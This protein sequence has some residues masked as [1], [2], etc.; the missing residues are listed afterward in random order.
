[1]R[2]AEYMIA[3]GGDVRLAAQ[4]L[5]DAPEGS[6]TEVP[7]DAFIEFCG[8]VEKL[9]EEEI[10]DRFGLSPG[11]AET[12]VPALLVYRALLL[13]TSAK[14]IT[15]PPASL[16]DGLLADLA[17]PPGV[18]LPGRPGG[19]Q[20]A[21]AGERGSAGR[22]VPPRRRARAGRWRI[23]P[24][25]CSTNSTP[26]T[27]STPATGCCSRSPRC[28]T[29]SACS[30]GLRAHHKHAQYLIQ[31]SE[32]FGLSSD[33]RAII[34]NVARYHRR[35]LPQQSHLPYMAL[36]RTERVRVNK[37]AAM[38]RIA[39]ALDAE[40]SQKVQDLRVRAADGAWLLEVQ[41]IGDLAM[42]RMKV[43]ARADLFHDV[44][45]RSLSWRGA[46]VQS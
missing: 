14:G 20:P 6:V 1:M 9:A 45:G 36:D 21:G 2:S 26:S 16:R 12:L 5:V 11:D 31:A 42:E 33:D 23:S 13:E 40:H 32:I 38:L 25:G 3:L 43:E 44:F 19:L 8:R 34:A 46:G 7:R 18:G 39:N 17:A 4:E 37:L 24:R 35:G 29:T 28:C 22:E 27:G 10:A 30:S 41:G 15:V